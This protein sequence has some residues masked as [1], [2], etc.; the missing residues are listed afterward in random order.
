MSKFYAMKILF[1]ITQSDLDCM[2][3]ARDK[4][5][6]TQSEFIRRA[7]RSYAAEQ[8]VAEYMRE[9]DRI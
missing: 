8:K 9:A 1:N 6:L 7:I 2:A 4:V 5:G 3:V